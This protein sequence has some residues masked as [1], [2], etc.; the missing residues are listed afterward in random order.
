MASNE[1]NVD[2]DVPQSNTV[3][4]EKQQPT[5]SPVPPVTQAPVSRTDGFNFKGHHFDLSSFSGL[6]MVPQW[7]SYIYQW[8]DDP[9]HYLIEKA[10]NAGNAIWSVGIGDQVVINGQTYTVFNQMSNVVNDDS[11]YGIFKI[12]WCDC[13]MADM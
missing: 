13:H 12:T 8:T 1:T 3:S 11:A 7:T 9:S 2:S 6:G 5:E 4:Q 10:S